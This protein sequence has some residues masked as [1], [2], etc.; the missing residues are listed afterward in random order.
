M[1]PKITSASNPDKDILD[2]SK[3]SSSLNEADKEL[4]SERELAI[5]NYK[6]NGVRP[7]RIAKADAQTFGLRKA[8]WDVYTPI[9]GVQN[10]QWMLEKDAESGDEFI[11]VKE[12]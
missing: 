10:G 4:L 9:E 7:T 2:Y 5:A 11:I 12:S 1:I 6:E 3:L 8:F